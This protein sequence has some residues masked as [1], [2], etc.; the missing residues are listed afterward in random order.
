VIGVFEATAITTAAGHACA[1][2]ASGGADCW[3][4]DDYGQLGSGNLRPLVRNATPVAFGQ[5]P[6][7]SR[8]E[9]GV[10]PRPRRS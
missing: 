7:G 8:R 6:A 10:R 2:F 4:Y 9:A 1:L 3:G 5:A